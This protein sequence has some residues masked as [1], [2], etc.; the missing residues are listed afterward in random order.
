AS[1]HDQPLA[2]VAMGGSAPTPRGGFVADVIEVQSLEE[3]DARIRGKIVYFHNPMDADS[4]RKGRALEAYSKAAAFRTKGASRAAVY[5][6]RAVLIHSLAS[7]S[8][9]TPHTGNVR[10]DETAERI[11]AAALSAEDAMLVHRLLARDEA[12]RIHLVLES[13]QKPDTESA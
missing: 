1:H 7:A 11:P 8:L 4:V 5:G 12:V 10:Y 6:A 13:E 3:L 2:L 9:R